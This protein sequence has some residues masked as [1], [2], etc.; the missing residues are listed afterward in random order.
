[1]PN[2][3]TRPAQI[4]EGVILDGFTEAWKAIQELHASVMDGPPEGMS[5]QD[6]VRVTSVII[7]SSLHPLRLCLEPYNPKALRPSHRACRDLII[8]YLDDYTDPIGLP[9]EDP[10][11]SN[12]MAATLDCLIGM[13]EAMLD[14]AP[15]PG[16]DIEVLVEA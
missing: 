5:E 15:A 16:Q 7:R 11:V 3:I 1:M 8:Q 10:A 14:R 13:H 12:W 6:M 4:V 9:P 2:V